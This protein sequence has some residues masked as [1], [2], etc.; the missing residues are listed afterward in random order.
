MS[1]HSGFPRILLLA[2]VCC[3]RQASAN[4]IVWENSQSIAPTAHGFRTTGDDPWTVSAALSP[5]ADKQRAYLAFEAQTSAPARMQVFWT[6]AGKPF[7]D[8]RSIHIQ[9]PASDSLTTHVFDLN[10]T[11]QFH[12]ADILRLDPSDRSSFEFRL[13]DA[14]LLSLEEVPEASLPQLI[15]FRCFTS[16]LHYRPGE[17]L[18]FGATLLPRNY[19]EHRSAKM[20]KVALTNSSGKRVAESMQQVRLSPGDSLK[21]M[22]GVLDT[23]ASLV[24]GP[25]QL[26]A[27]FTD[28]MTGL[29]LTSSH[30]FAVQKNGDPA[31]YETPF[32]FVKDFSLVYGPDKRWHI[33]SISGNFVGT[34]EWREPGQER[35]FSHGSSA[36]LKTWTHHA[37][38]LSITDETYPDGNGRYADRNIWAPHVIAHEGTYYM[39]YTSVN[40][41]V[42]QSVSLATSTDLFNWREHEKNPVFTLEDVDWALWRRDGWADCRDPMVLKADD[43]FYL[44]VTATAKEADADGN[45][46][47]VAVARSS[48]LVSWSTGTIALRTPLPPESP[49]VWKQGELYCMLTSSNGAGSFISEH[50]VHG[51]RTAKFPRPN[52]PAVEKYVETS[53]S[54]A[55]EVALSPATPIMGSLTWRLYGNSI[56]FFKIQPGAVG[57]DG[58][59]PVQW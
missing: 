42:S 13:G 44:Y 46:G 32:Q 53:G 40:E 47:V 12:G 36:D 5:R 49:Q 15:Q 16:R 17:L 31:V 23:T 35:T 33:F 41:H 10:A 50:P 18:E 7:L 37:P 25:Y 52:I 48:D 30:A 38:V 2:F 43:G 4:P 26:I 54:Y 27:E 6:S 45:R 3:C 22:R 29:K 34:H 21:E 8:E 51:W 57:P 1:I 28:L 24:P 55:E 14:R 56:Y 11:G 58:Y 19:P 20:L 59:E 9:V 39:F